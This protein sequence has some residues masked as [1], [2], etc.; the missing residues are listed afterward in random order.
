MIRAFEE[1][2]LNI[3]LCTSTLIEGVNTA[4][5]NVIVYDNK[6]KKKPLDFFTFNNIRSRS[7]RMFRHFIGHVFVFDEPPQEDL[8]FV[9]MPAINPTDTTPSSLLIQLSNDDV[10]EALREKVDELLNQDILPVNI[11]KNISSIEPE[12]L[13]DTATYLINMD[14]RELTKCSWSSRP[15][16]ED[17]LFSSNIIWEYLGGAPSARQSSMYSASMMTLWVWK[18]YSRRNV[19]LFRK[20]MIQSQIERNQQPDEAVENVLAFLRGWAS[21][22]YPKYLM[23]LSDVANHILTKRGLKGCNYSPF[24][25]SIEHLFQPT[26][27]SA[28]E[29]YGLPTEISEK[30]LKS[31][32]FDKDDELESVVNSLRIRELNS[33]ADGVFEK[34]VI[35]D[36][37]Q[38]IGSKLFANRRVVQYKMS[39]NQ[40]L[41]SNIK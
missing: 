16:Y 9:D 26:S 8:P 24:A 36:F 35:E 3:L 6:L 29:E 23:A 22:N 4:A 28:L 38:G 1:G 2:K 33:F 39:L 15:T 32:L 30:L 7:G 34:R 18:L 12:F 31:N 5:K 41:I 17:I 13:L 37:Q 11:L 25:V 27:F 40:P 19:S 14:V 20:E 10:P 21:F